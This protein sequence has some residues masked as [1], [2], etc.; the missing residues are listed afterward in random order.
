MAGIEKRVEGFL[1]TWRRGNELDSFSD[2]IDQEK[3]ARMARGEKKHGPLDLAMDSRDFIQEGIEELIDFLN[4]SEMAMLQG[5]LPFCTWF[6]TDQTI[7]FVIYRL[8]KG[9]SDQCR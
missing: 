6:S 4:Y 5:K 2:R 1:E 9:G 8:H 7:R 3:K